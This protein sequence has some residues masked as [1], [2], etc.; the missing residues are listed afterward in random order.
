VGEAIKLRLEKLLRPCL[1][2]ARLAGRAWARAAGI[3]QA[4]ASLK[5]RDRFSPIPLLIAITILFLAKVVPEFLAQWYNSDDTPNLDTGSFEFDLVLVQLLVLGV[6]AGLLLF[7]LAVLRWRKVL[8]HAS[9]A[10][11]LLASLVYAG[12]I[13]DAMEHAKF[14]A[15][16]TEY[17]ACARRAIQYA[18]NA[19]FRVCNVKA[20]WDS[21][22]MI[23]YDSAGQI[24]LDD[25]H[26]SADFKNFVIY[27]RSPIL[28]C[29]I[30]RKAKLDQDF[31]YVHFACD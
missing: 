6:E 1:T 10:T 20:A 11:L 31:Y 18:E 4:S 8:S 28:R 23:I 30:G 16:R 14:V 17:D 26:Q 29:N 25:D 24:M 5:R 9:G 12:P 7:Y 15:F 2:A 21:Y 13:F 3:G 22:A 19:R 27:N